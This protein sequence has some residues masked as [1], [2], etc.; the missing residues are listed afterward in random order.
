MWHAV[1]R[2]KL[3]QCNSLSGISVMSKDKVW[4]CNYGMCVHAR[5]GQAQDNVPQMP[6]NVQIAPLQATF[7]MY[8]LAQE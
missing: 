5:H 8:Y 2:A 3:P 6:A 7:I 1:P 4:Q